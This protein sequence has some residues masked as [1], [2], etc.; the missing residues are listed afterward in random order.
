MGSDHR[1]TEG[2]IWPSRSNE[3]IFSHSPRFRG[4]GC[5]RSAKASRSED[6]QIEEPVCGG[7]PPMSAELAGKQLELLQEA[8]GSLGRVAVLWNARD[9]A[10]TNIFSAIQTAA[11]VLGVTV[12]PLG[13]H[14]DKDIDRAIAT[15]TA[16]RPDALFMITDVLTS[17]YTSKVVDFAV[18]HQ[19]PTMFQGSGP[20]AEGGLMFYGAS[21][22]ETYRRAA[23][24]VDG[25]RQPIVFM[26]CSP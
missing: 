23:S 5:H 3:Q 18:Q 19:L 24:Y 1:D 10:M 11:P 6:L 20:V 16:A 9:A 13:V 2:A 25:T 26:V 15:M 17:R 12:Q 7:D 22:T 8:M 14:E 4:K 21:L